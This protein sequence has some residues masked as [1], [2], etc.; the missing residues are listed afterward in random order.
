[1]VT[2]EYDRCCGLGDTAPLEE[3]Q[4]LS[5]L[6]SWVYRVEEFCSPDMGDGDADWPVTGLEDVG[7]LRV[8][9]DLRGYSEEETRCAVEPALGCGVYTNRARRIAL[10]ACGWSTEGELDS[11]EDGETRR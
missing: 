1:V 9:G 7:V 11:S 5:R 10:K 3:L 4:A 6:W 8:L 2:D